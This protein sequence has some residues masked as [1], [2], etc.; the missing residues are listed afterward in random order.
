LLFAIGSGAGAG[1]VAYQLKPSFSDTATLQEL[2]GVNVLGR[3]AYA[4]PQAAK[5]G[6][7]KDVAGFTLA[8]GG[9]FVLFMV[10]VSLVD[11]VTPLVQGFLRGGAA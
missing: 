1:F 7:R 3:V 10:A 4:F 2:T 5:V 6:K 8:I 9:L 11:T